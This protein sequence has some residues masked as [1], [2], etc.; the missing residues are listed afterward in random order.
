MEVTDLQQKKEADPCVC[1]HTAASNCCG[2]FNLHQMITNQI[3]NTSPRVPGVFVPISQHREPPRPGDGA[4]GALSVTVNDHLTLALKS[5]TERKKGGKGGRGDA[6]SLQDG[7][8][9]WGGGSQR[10]QGMDKGGWGGGKCVLE[11]FQGGGE[12]SVPQG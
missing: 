2:D 3:T 1:R 6:H 4:A 5:F 12:G 7:E 11:S 10:R 8:R 9:R